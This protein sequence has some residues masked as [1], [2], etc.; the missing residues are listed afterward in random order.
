MVDN[1]GIDSSPGW[2]NRK[3]RAL[4]QQIA[5]LRSERRASAT[6]IGSGGFVVDGGDVIML[7]DDGSVMF[8][9]G[10]QTHGDRG[11][12]IARE[13]GTVA[14]ELRKTFSNSSS[15]TLYLYD[16]QGAAMLTEEPLGNGISRPMLPVPLQPVTAA[17]TALNTGPWGPEVVVDS[18]TFTTTHQAWFA[19]HNHFALF[20]VQ[21]A[22]SDITTAAEVRVVNAVDQNPLNPFFL[23]DWLGVRPAGT[24]GYVEV[25]TSGLDGLA[26][27]G[28]SHTEISVQVQVRRSAGAGTL[29]VAVP[30][31]HGWSA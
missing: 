29:T 30:T 11:L 27:P 15:Q 3:F 7:D 22:A 18:A 12:T 23:V 14:L 4:E 31:A 10:A 13:D 20:R 26:L 1:L 16:D 6:T 2:I 5:D 25:V 17:S 28:T 24:T 19:R 21:I 9:L 8:R